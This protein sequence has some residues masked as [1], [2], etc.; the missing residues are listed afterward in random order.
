MKTA[1]KNSVLVR[2]AIEMKN[3]FILDFASAV[4][5]TLQGA[6]TISLE[7][8]NSN[9]TLSLATCMIIVNNTKPEEQLD[10]A[11][12]ANI[13]VDGTVGKFLENLPVEKQEKFARTSCLRLV[14]YAYLDDE[15]VVVANGI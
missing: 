15:T 10:G 6:Q 11:E 4:K 7:R 2:Y 8:N 5:A 1:N 14:T 12:I 9:K 3:E 13:V